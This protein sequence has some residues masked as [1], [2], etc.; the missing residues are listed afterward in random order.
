MEETPQLKID[1]IKFNKPEDCHRIDI[2][3]RNAE[4]GV[5]LRPDQKAIAKLRSERQKKAETGRL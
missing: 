2:V 1:D 5:N 4:K 3:K